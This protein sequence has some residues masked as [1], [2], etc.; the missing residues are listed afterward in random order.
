MIIRFPT[1]VRGRHRAFTLLEMIVA[2][3]I[4]G[5][6]STSA[7]AMFLSVRTAALEADAR[8]QVTRDGQVVLDT[9]ENDLRF[10]GAGVPLG[11]N[12]DVGTSASGK[13]LLPIL[14]VAR[15]DNLVFL[16]DLPYPNAEF[17][18]IAALAYL[19]SSDHRIVVT[20]ELSGSCIPPVGSAGELACKTSKT[21]LLPDLQSAADCAGSSGSVGVSP[22]AAELEAARTCPW[23]MNKWLIGASDRIY[24]TIVDA[25]GRWHE[26]TNRDNAVG[27][28]DAD[29]KFK[30]THLEHEYPASGQH[31]FASSELFGDTG[32]SYVAI[33]DRVFYAIEES[34]TP[35]SPCK[36]TVGGNCIL[37]RRQCWGRLEDPATAT[38]P[39]GGTSAFVG[40]SASIAN[41]AANDGTGWE[42]VMS[43]IEDVTFRYFSDAATQVTGSGTG[44]PLAA[45]DAQRVK[46]IEVEVRMRRSVPGAQP[47][48]TLADVVRRRFLLP[49][50]Q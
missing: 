15:D 5:A 2:L 37:R 30:A 38:F 45:T 42:T 10:F 33:L 22:T 12:D 3:T 39:A 13:R 23:G 18:G 31:T 14:R 6:L 41:C 35:G 25:K 43:G 9:I 29:G 44:Q 40:T 11:I 32:G 28:S 47:A 50:Q 34:S 48:R 19:N 46:A 49:N 26:R 17:S 1:S 20:S 36:G 27:N 7:I 21:T 8:A 16:G 24:F 4:A